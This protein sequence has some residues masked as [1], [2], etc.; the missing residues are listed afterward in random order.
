MSYDH[1][2][3]SSSV[4]I[5]SIDSISSP[6]TIKETLN[7][8]GWK[9]AMLEEIH[10]LEDNNTWKLVDLPQGKKVVGCKWVFAVKVNPDGSVARLKARFVVKGYAQ[11]YG[12]DYSDTFSLVAKLNSV[13]QLERKYQ[14]RL[15]HMP[16]HIL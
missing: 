6:K 3:S 4:L 11:T 5:A 16:E 14:N 2:S 15:L 9:N 13:W 10:A 1:L 7:H 8:P 12:V